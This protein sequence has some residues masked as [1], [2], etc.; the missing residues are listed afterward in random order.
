M[1]RIVSFSPEEK[2]LLVAKIKA[3]FA[4][5]LDQEIGGFDAEFLLDFFGNEI[6]KHFYNRG[7][8]DAL[9]EIRAKLD[10]LADDVGYALEKP[11]TPEGKQR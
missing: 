3:Y 11:V 1:P 9:D 10:L 4:R 6:G 2:A 5:E 8:Y 7:L